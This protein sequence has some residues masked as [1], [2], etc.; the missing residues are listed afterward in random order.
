M[1]CL[2]IRRSKFIDTGKF[3]EPTRLPASGS[4][5]FTCFP[6]PPPHPQPPAWHISRRT[7]GEARRRLGWAVKTRGSNKTVLPSIPLPNPI[8]MP[9]SCR[10]SPL[11][12]AG[13]FLT[14]LSDASLLSSLTPASG[15]LLFNVPL[16]YS[17]VIGR[18][19]RVSVC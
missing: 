15:V 14:F 2:Y 10:P 3:V 9:G 16:A 5:P 11:P 18:L 8:K 7:R 12:T 4:F 19:V 17:N 13:K 1:E 6:I